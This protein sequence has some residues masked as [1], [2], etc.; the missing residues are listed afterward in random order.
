MPKRNKNRQANRAVPQRLRNIGIDVAASPQEDVESRAASAAMDTPCQPIT[1]TT[2]LRA[3]IALALL[4]GVL[5]AVGFLA[6][7]PAD[8]DRDRVARVQDLSAGVPRPQPGATP[9]AAYKA[10]RQAQAALDWSREYLCYTP[11]QQAC[12]SH[13]VIVTALYLEFQS[14]LYLQVES[15]L[16]HHGLSDADFEGFW[17]KNVY[18]IVDEA[19]P[20][21]SPAEFEAEYEARIDR[22]QRDVVPKIRDCAGLIATLQPII[23]E[24]ARRSAELST[25]ALTVRRFEGSAY[26]RLRD[27]KIDGNRATGTIKVKLRFGAF[28]EPE[29]LKE[30]AGDLPL[31]EAAG[32][33]NDNPQ[34]ILDGYEG[35]YSWLWESGAEIYSLARSMHHSHMVII[36]LP[37]GDL[38]VGPD[39]ESLKRLF[40]SENSDAK[41]DGIDDANNKDAE[42]S[43]LERVDNREES[44]EEGISNNGTR[45]VMES[46]ITF[47]LVD[48]MWRIDSM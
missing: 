39:D 9:A 23:R 29:D 45:T 16:E 36:G 34:V 28:V 43:V 40:E 13:T 4:T 10:F 12:F 27:L 48:G 2:T 30:A 22:W 20:A 35:L 15:A 3:R 26:G 46:R 6:A 19:T 44:E 7:V 24:G 14:D 8:Q 5:L 38:V 47:Q 33:D 11:R 41:R 42:E 1:G 21:K 37:T 31:D 32:S 18:E 25:V 17:P